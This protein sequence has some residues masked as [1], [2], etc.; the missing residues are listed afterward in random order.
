MHRLVCETCGGEMFVP[1][2]KS[3]KR[4]EG[5]IK[6]MWCPYCKAVKDFRECE[7]LVESGAAK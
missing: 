4:E 7:F 2:K 6:T 5:H 3:R 1:R